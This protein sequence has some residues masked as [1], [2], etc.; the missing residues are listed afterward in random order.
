MMATR[1]RTQSGS[2][3]PRR[4]GLVLSSLI[5]VAFRGRPRGCASRRQ[6]I[7]NNIVH[8]L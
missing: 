1:T 5:L 3:G 6:L 7:T 8:Q 4:A 2:V